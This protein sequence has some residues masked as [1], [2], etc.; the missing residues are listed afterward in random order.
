MLTI[1]RPFVQSLFNALVA[2]GRVCRVDPGGAASRQPDRAPLLCRT[3]REIDACFDTLTSD[4]GLPTH[5]DVYPV[6]IWGLPRD[7]EDEGNELVD[8]FWSDPDELD[9]YRAVLNA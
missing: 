9:R 2:S 4:V 7:V 8:I 3:V 6:H 5:D 1:G